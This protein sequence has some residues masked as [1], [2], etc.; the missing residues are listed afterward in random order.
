M[1]H[2]ALTRPAADDLV[3]S[4]GIESLSPPTHDE[5]AR[6]TFVAA[7]RKHLMVDMAA[8]MR[9]LYDSEVAPAVAGRQGHAPR[10]AREVRR[11][12]L[13]RPYFRAWSALRYS[14]QELTWWTVQ[15]QVERALPALRAACRSLAE[16]RPAGG[17]LRLDPAT[18]M[19]REVTSLDIHLMP[20][21]FHSEFAAEDV[22]QG[23]VY[24][25]GTA[26]FGGALKLRTRG[27]GVAA[28]VARWI[29]ATRPE[30]EPQRILDLGC[31]TGANTLPYLDAFPGAEL[32]GVDVG[33]PVLRYAHARAELLGR[34]VHYSQQN[35]ESLDFPDGSF[36][37]VVSSFFLHEQSL[38]STA[39]IL[40]ECHRLLRPGGLMVH[41][42]LPPATEV[43]PYYNF[44]LDWDAYY[45]NE[46]HYAAFR[47]L[48]LR[49]AVAAAGFEP[50][51]YFQTR[52]P[53]W[54]TVSEQEFVDC[55]LGRT[56]APPH[57]NGASWFIF[58]AER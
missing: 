1:P 27:G 53:N 5:H 15:P 58:G 46:P 13:D 41:M 55:V 47:A 33:A 7:L 26:V 23:A 11:E 29:R 52:I 40:R 43:D 44:Y 39:R 42:E 36:D 48:D 30:F 10:D 34:R 8:R 37:L 22:A 6:Q 20:G 18:P 14:A 35:A 9:R 12:M 24:T 31:T 21:C 45:N 51:R 4:A 49:G 3:E 50:G 28:S 54:G 16:R 19:P 32:H 25:L 2:A 56:P 57:G 38:A 17:S